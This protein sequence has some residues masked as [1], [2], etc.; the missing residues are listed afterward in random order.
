MGG[1]GFVSSIVTGKKEMYLRTDVG[2]A[3]KYDYTKKRWGQLFSFINEA[4]KGYL[5]VKGIAIDPTDENIVYF[6]CGCAYFSEAKTAIYKTTDGGKTFTEIEITNM[7]QVHGNGDGRQCTEPIGVDPDNHN[8]IYV[9]GDVTFGESALIKSTDGG[10]TWNYVLGY[11]KLGL[12]KYDIKYPSWT[13]RITR[14]TI[15]GSYSQQNGV[16][17]LKIYDGKIYVATGVK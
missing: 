10:K 7:I 8:T 9:G 1:A 11:N 12:Y 4:K 14:G 17:A 5:S 13:N 2:G 16:D 3:Y 15:N 6:L